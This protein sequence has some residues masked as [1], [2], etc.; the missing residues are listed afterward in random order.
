V[1]IC[2]DTIDNDCNPATIDLFDNDGDFFNCLA[3]CNDADSTVFPNATEV[4]CDG[5]DND[6]NVG[7]LDVV[8]NDSDF[9]DCNSDCDDA[10]PAI[11][12]G[13][14]EFCFDG[15]DNN[16]DG[17][18]DA[19]DDECACPSPIDLDGDG[20]RC[21]DCNDGA[22]A[23]N[24]GAIELC[25]D[26][27]DNDC[28]P[29][30]PDIFDLDEDG[31]T[32]DVDCLDTDPL[33]NGAAI[34]LCNDGVDNDCDTL[35]DNA[36]PDCTGCPDVDGDGYPAGSCG[37]DCLD[38]DPNVNPGAT[39]VCNDG[40]DNDCDPGTL[41]LADADGDGEDCTTDCNDND[42]SIGTSAPESC[43]D[44]IDNDCDGMID[45]VTLDS[46]LVRFGDSVKF[47]GIFGDSGLGISWTAETFNDAGWGNGLYGIGYQVGPPGS[48]AESLLLTDVVE[49]ADA[50]YTR[51]R[52]AI[53]DVSGV[54]ALYI[55]ADYDDGYVAWINGVEVYRS[56]EMPVGAPDW[57]SDPVLHE[58]S[59]GSVPD[60]GTLIDISTP[61][62]PALHNGVNVLAVGVYNDF[63]EMGA[64]SS[65]LVIVPRLSMDFGSD[66]PDCLCEDLDDDGY[67]GG[68]CGVDCD[69]TDPLVNPGATEIGCD[70]IDNDCDAGTVDVFDGDSD[71]VTCTT[72][73]DDSNPDV[74]PGNPEIGCD[75]LDNDCDQFTPDVIDADMDT[76]N[77]AQ[78]CDDDN[79][80]VHPGV[81]EVPCDSI[82]NDCTTLTAD[83]QDVDGDGAFCD[84]DCDDGDPTRFPAQYE[85]CDDAIDN[86]CDTLTDVADTDDCSCGDVDMDGYE[87]SDCDDGDP[88]RN[89][90]NA[91]LCNDAID[92]DCDISTLDV[93]DN[94]MDGESCLTDCD[95][96]D[97]TVATGLP[98]ICNDGLDNDCTPGTPDIF[99]A[100]MDG[101][102]C[103]VDCDDLDEN[104]NS[105]VIEVCAD[106][107]DNDCDPVTLDL[108]DT[109]G[110]GFDCSVDCDDGVAA[111]NPDADEICNDAIDNDC[112]PLT[113]DIGDADGDGFTCDLD[114]DDTDP[115]RYPDAPENCGDSIDGDC[116]GDADNQDSDCAC[117]DADNDDYECDDC[118]DSEP[119]A[120]PGNPEV[121]NDGID[122]DCNPATLD[123]GDNDGDGYTCD[124]DCD[125]ADP[126]INPGAT[127]IC[128]DGIDNDCSA[129][130]PDLLDVDMDTEFCDTDCNDNDPSVNSMAAEIGCDLIDNDCDPAT[131]DLAD[132]D[133]DSF[134][135]VDV[136]VR[137]AG[138]SAFA[139][140]DGSVSILNN[141]IVGNSLPS[142][143]GGGIWVDDLLSSNPGIVANNVITDNTAE[144]GGGMDHSAF[145]G[146]VR[147]NIL[148]GNTGGDLFGGGAIGATLSANQIVD[149]QYSSPGSGNYRPAE[150]SP[151]VDAADTSV[152]PINDLDR[153]ERPFD[154]DGD[155]IALADIGAYEFPSGEIFDLVFV[156]ANQLSW[157]TASATKFNLYRGWMRN[158]RL[159]GLYTQDPTQPIPEHFCDL[160]LGQVPFSDPYVPA[161]G[162]VVFYLVT[163][164]GAA[165]EGTLGVRSTGEIRLNHNPC[166][167]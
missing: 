49:G 71:G 101:E 137:G 12:P 93:F 135:C 38:S 45:T 127:E 159:Q 62:L 29:F 74:F 51:A 160:L 91:E 131:N 136:S 105:T 19:S 158:L 35:I 48:G 155:M 18:V 82:D 30:T 161:Q 111:T 68:A 11:K 50:V 53:P 65:D 156:S 1:E 40:I 149:P 72:D 80:A 163:K 153:V 59:N 107:I 144:F 81:T 140:G 24:P 39:E 94:D 78:D 56:P 60:Y 123:L 90:G 106:A 89:P 87:C 162:E 22:I 41:D 8:D 64:Y 47:N 119:L 70:T 129:G 16:C 84:V 88:A 95:D 143:I 112:D 110:D 34:E 67:A 17:F 122:N 55:G 148:F 58:S 99:D 75:F 102:N 121:C 125:D 32:C 124:N 20:Y 14:L 66:D 26:G 27:I 85:K 132:A 166:G 57:D 128:G 113:L 13:A 165:Y 145:F 77:C 92:N 42:A 76:Y 150:G 7:T 115:A 46:A 52:F 118:D 36:D 103:D 133:G 10:N 44:M 9:F 164:V 126:L 147:N 4:V 83:V 5:V 109:D 43:A 98:E 25:N 3:D 142:G 33:R 15:I 130:T 86:D 108:F 154:G 141:T 117:S 23:I 79:P 167:P 100:D 151:L 69:D 73:C 139:A 61:G 96:D 157:D 97:F 146:A 138:V 54:N 37:V 2:S 28:N 21:T 63:P 120:F 152:A 134:Y 6:C 114:C 104:I 116:D 31:D